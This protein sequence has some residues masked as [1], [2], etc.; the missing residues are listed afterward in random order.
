MMTVRALCQAAGASEALVLDAAER[1]MIRTI[2]RN[3]TRL[4]DAESGQAWAETYRAAVVARQPPPPPPLPTP[5]PEAPAE[6][7]IGGTAA[8]RKG[9]LDVLF[10]REGREPEARQQPPALLEERQEGERTWSISELSIAA[11]ACRQTITTAIYSQSLP[12]VGSEPFTISDRTAQAY[13]NRRL[14][15]RAGMAKRAGS[16]AGKSGRAS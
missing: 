5:A 14:E 8:V 9:R 6:N 10:W 2:W 4:I 15:K 7:A 11:G 12:I 1:G 13:I 16:K 3:R